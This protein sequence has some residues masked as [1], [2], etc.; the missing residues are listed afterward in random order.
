MK[1]SGS[2]RVALDARGLEVFEA[3]KFDLCTGNKREQWFF[4]QKGGPVTENEFVRSYRT[5]TGAGDLDHAEVNRN[6]DG[7]L[8]PAALLG[9]GVVGLG[10]AVTSAVLT[11]AVP[12]QPL[13]QPS[14]LSSRLPLGLDL[15]IGAGLV[16]L[17]FGAWG[18]YET[19]DSLRFEDTPATAH[20]LTE[21]EGRAAAERY[22]GKLSESVSKELGNGPGSP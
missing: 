17:G 3:R 7:M 5:L 4:C 20:T 9:V 22:N 1:A 19:V 21:A 18:I 13:P 14:P 15:A 2:S 11:Y 12:V 6:D 10:V 8:V 16:G